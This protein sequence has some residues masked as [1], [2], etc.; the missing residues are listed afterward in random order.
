MRIDSES[1][2][3]FF[4]TGI[5]LTCSLASYLLLHLTGSCKWECPSA[6]FTVRCLGSNSS[7]PLGSLGLGNC[8]PSPSAFWL[9]Q[10]E[11]SALCLQ[12]RPN[13]QCAPHATQFDVSLL[14]RGWRNG[15]FFSRQN[16]NTEFKLQPIWSY[17]NSVVFGALPCP[18]H[19]VT[20]SVVT[21][22]GGEPWHASTADAPAKFKP[23]QHPSHGVPIFAASSWS[24]TMA[25]HMLYKNYSMFFE[26][27]TCRKLVL[28]QKLTF[29][30]VAKQ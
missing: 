29:S 26:W 13:S 14:S 18:P 9:C 12:L 6:K 22:F 11:V 5:A 20:G 16:I 3:N 19:N 8:N 10:L 1:L 7:M 28:R 27:A 17:R 24:P 23:R 21:V 4:H 30:D 25:P 2:S 15:T